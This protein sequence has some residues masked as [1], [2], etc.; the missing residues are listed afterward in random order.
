[1]ELAQ[2]LAYAY[3]LDQTA[4]AN[5]KAAW[6][7]HLLLPQSTRTC[8]ENYRPLFQFPVVSAVRVS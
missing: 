7:L 1:M 5:T 2:I 4:A 6:L 8:T 3:G